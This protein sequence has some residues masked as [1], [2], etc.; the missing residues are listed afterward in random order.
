MVG[1][2]GVVEVE[3]LS[4]LQSPA[5]VTAVVKRVTIC[6]TVLSGTHTGTHLHMVM[7][8][9]IPRCIAIGS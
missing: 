3:I 6:G 1:A 5:A 7:R 9:L 4:R 8:I 2:T